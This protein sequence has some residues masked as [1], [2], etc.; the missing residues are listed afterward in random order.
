SSLGPRWRGGN[1]AGLTTPSGSDTRPPASAAVESIAYR[2]YPDPS[3]TLTTTR[4]PREATASA[5]LIV[6]IPL[7]PV[8]RLVTGYRVPVARSGRLQVGVGIVGEA[9]EA[10]FLQVVAEQ[11]CEAAGERREGDVTTIG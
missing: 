7:A 6:V 5:G 11:V 1:T 3:Y 2:L 4:P 8:Q 10:V 9:L